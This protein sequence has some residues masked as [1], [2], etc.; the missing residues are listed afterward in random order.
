MDSHG[1]GSK[2]GLPM[3]LVGSG[4]SNVKGVMDSHGY[5][6]KAGLPMWLVGS[7]ISN[8]KDGMWDY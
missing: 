8:V 7:G 1:D 2:A 6:S 5:G 4:I 3:W